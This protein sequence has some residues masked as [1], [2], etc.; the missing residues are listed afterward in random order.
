MTVEAQ[1]LLVFWPLVT[2][3]MLP[4]LPGGMRRLL[5]AAALAVPLLWLVPLSAA[6]SSGGAFSQ[7]LAGFAAPL[8]I[9]LVTDSVSLL[10]LWLAA[11][12]FG[13]A[14]VAAHVEY[15]PASAA[16]QRFWPPWMILVAATNALLLSADLFNLYVALE[17]VTLSAVPL[18]AIAGG[19]A[20]RAA[21]RYLLMGL[22]A[23][24]AYLLGLALLYSAYGTLDMY[25]LADLVGPEPLSEVALI[26]MTAGLLL[27]T[28]IFP[29]HVWLPPA[30]AAAPGAVSAMLSA[31]V[32][33]LS[34]Y[35][36]YRL[37]FW[38]GS[39]LDAD[40]LAVLMG[41]LGASAILYGSVAALVQPRL[42]L[43][44]AYSTVA[45]LGYLLL[46]FPL[47]GVLAWH[48]AI[49]HLVSHAFAK[50][51]MFLAAMNIMHA[52]GGNDRLER[53][54][55]ADGAVPVSL[56]AFGLA[57]ISIMGLPPSGGFLAKWMLLEAAWHQG[58]WGWMAVIAV[59]SLLASAYVFRVLAAALRSPESTQSAWE[60]PSA[61]LGLMAFLLAMLSLAA[62]FVSAPVLALLGDGPFAG[63]SP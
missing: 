41:L 63:G 62:G 14:G 19:E 2:A 40:A 44:I 59:G 10:L 20:L 39:G 28:A 26:L 53:I 43:V 30:H 8:G 6:V 61:L 31:I 47:A 35:L 21:M 55:G 57:G 4:L 13:L 16:G 46:L 52:L 54:A 29:L 7:N 37:W 32:V 34:L 38:A 42:K 17:L 1:A 51:A 22:L 9:R 36:L 18:I 50:S 49:Y 27:K 11:V 58:A 23:S 25:L 5:V 15:P 56:F 12:V 48:G 3:C 60:R 24:L 45:Q 33:K